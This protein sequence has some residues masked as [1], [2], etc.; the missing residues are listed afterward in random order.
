MTKLFLIGMG[1]FAGTLLRY[2]I[3]GLI[4]NLSKSIAFP[5]GTLAVNLLGCLAIGFLSQLAESYG[6]FSS[7]ARTFVFV[8][9]LGA[10]TTYSTFASETVNLARDG[11][12]SLALANLGLH[13]FLGL[14]AV[15]LGRMS[16][17][18]LWR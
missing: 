13:I 7:E 9:L 5:Y 4:Q 15:W 18:L 14:A 12:G 10:F 1:G 16:V 2:G 3:S 8:G 6:V 11:Q 17:N